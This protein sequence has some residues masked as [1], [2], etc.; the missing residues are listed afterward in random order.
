MVRVSDAVR[1]VPVAGRGSLRERTVAGHEGLH[2]GTAWE[3]TA[4]SLAEVLDEGVREW[5]V[6]NFGKSSPRVGPER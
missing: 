2:A 3:R 5:P 4:A 1:R 6:L